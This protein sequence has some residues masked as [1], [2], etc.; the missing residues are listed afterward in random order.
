MEKQ[1]NVPAIL[2]E[3]S[4]DVKEATDILLREKYLLLGKMTISCGLLASFLL[5]CL[6]TGM[7]PRVFMYLLDALVG[8]CLIDVLFEWEM[9]LSEQER[10]DQELFL[11]TVSSGRSRRKALT[12]KSPDPSS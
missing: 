8:R 3:V 5:V 1:S 4:N 9:V 6:L 11:Q 12:G 10:S 2:D 7:I